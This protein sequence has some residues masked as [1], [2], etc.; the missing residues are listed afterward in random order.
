MADMKITLDVEPDKFKECLNDYYKDALDSTDNVSEVLSFCKFLNNTIIVSIDFDD[1]LIYGSII[2]DVIESYKNLYDDK[3]TFSVSSDLFKVWDITYSELINL[4]QD[5]FDKYDILCDE[6]DHAFIMEYLEE[7]KELPERDLCVVSLG[8]TN[9]DAQLEN[10]GLYLWK[11]YLDFRDRLE[12]ADNL[13]EIMKYI[14]IDYVS[15]ARDF[16][17]DWEETATYAYKSM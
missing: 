13:S 11:H 10:F 12:S 16:V 6:Y 4:L 5:I 7:N 17:K 9:R 2:V 1:I 8:E 15:L 14:K 3:I